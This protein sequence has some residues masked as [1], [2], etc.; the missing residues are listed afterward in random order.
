MWGSASIYKWSPQV[1]SWLD[2]SHQRCSCN[3][4]G[5]SSSSKNFM[6]QIS[7]MQVDF[8]FYSDPAFWGSTSI[9]D[10]F[11]FFQNLFSLLWRSQNMLWGRMAGKGW[12]LCHC[13]TMICKYF[14]MRGKG[15]WLCV[16]G[17]LYSVQYKDILARPTMVRRYTCD[18]ARLLSQVWCVEPNTSLGYEMAEPP[19]HH[20]IIPIFLRRR[21][22]SDRPTRQ[23]SCASLWRSGRDTHAFEPDKN[24]FWHLII[25]FLVT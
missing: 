13:Q 25:S 3:Y 1:D 8:W 14:W 23:D 17:R 20:H 7:G 21:L 2:L 24:Q 9:T 6:Q 22:V 4:D 5:Y 18:K 19:H 10:H 16:V 12:W 15:Q 11:H